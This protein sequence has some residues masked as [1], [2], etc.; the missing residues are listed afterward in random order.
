M[1][2]KRKET[3]DKSTGG[4]VSAV[5]NPVGQGLTFIQPIPFER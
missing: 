3:N 4:S 5:A 2:N 1:K